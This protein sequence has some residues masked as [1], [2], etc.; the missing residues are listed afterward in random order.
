MPP[1]PTPTRRRPPLS[2]AHPDDILASAGAQAAAICSPTDT[3]ADLIQRSARTK[4]A[5]FRA[6]PGACARRTQ[7]V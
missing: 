2:P 4:K 1:T 5:I 3:N 7:T 6:K